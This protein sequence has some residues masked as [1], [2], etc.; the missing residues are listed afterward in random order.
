MPSPAELG[1]ERRQFVDD[2]RRQ[3]LARL[4][5]DQEIR[6]GDQRA[7]DCEHLLLAAGQRQTGIGAPLVQDREQFVDARQ[8][9]RS[10]ALCRR[11]EEDSP[12]R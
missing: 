3:P 10:F 12:R 5:E 9:P 8:R 11:A 2:D 4:V 6:I 7:P 1:Q